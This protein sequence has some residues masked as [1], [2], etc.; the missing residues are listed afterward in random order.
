MS[1]RALGKKRAPSG[2]VEGAEKVIINLSSRSFLITL[3]KCLLV[4][5]KHSCTD[6]VHH[7]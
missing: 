5:L 7:R 2:L 4:L 1:L 6:M 3:A